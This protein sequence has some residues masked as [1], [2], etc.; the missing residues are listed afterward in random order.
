ML[1]SSVQ[2]AGVGGWGVVEAVFVTRD[3]QFRATDAVH[4]VVMVL[5]QIT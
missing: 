4:H 3:L 1:R 2:K 5:K